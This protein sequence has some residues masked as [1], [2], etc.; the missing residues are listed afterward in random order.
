MTGSALRGKSV[1][2]A[3]DELGADGYPLEWHKTI[4]HLVRAQAE[5]RCERCLHPYRGG[6][7]GNG[8]WSRCDSRCA[9]GG[10]LRLWQIQTGWVEVEHP[11]RLAG[12]LAEHPVEARWRILT[13]HHL[14]GVKTDLRWWNLASLCQ[15]CHLHIQKK[16]QMERV[17]PFEHSGWF[18][19]HAAGWYAFAYLG[20]ELTREETLERMDELL[21]LERIA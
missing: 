2:R 6:E 5:H 7:H 18:K 4:K 17:F 13:V 9:H 15:R 8:E 16:V 12:E 3:Y 11:T 1:M 21:G 19:P 20:E 10:P 14:N